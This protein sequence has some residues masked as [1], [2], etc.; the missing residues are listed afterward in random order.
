M[1]SFWTIKA[2]RIVKR[3]YFMFLNFLM[4]S[5]FW[6]IKRCIERVEIALRVIKHFMFLNFLMVWTIKA[7]RIVKHFYFMPLNFLMV[8]FFLNH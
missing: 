6:T 8:S 4:V 1:V 3:F 5:F 7:L 2:L